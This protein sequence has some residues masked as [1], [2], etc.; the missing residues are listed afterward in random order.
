LLF[1][2]IDSK[3][4]WFATLGAGPPPPNDSTTDCNSF[5]LISNFNRV[6]DVETAPSAVDRL[7]Y[8]PRN[9]DE[10][11]SK[12]IE[13]DANYHDDLRYC[14]NPNGKTTFNS[15]SFAA[16]LLKAASVPLPK[17]PETPLFFH[18]GWSEPI[19]SSQFQPH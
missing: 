10:L 1:S 6:G 14:W 5:Q 17:F 8:D 15:N 4:N 12:L 9:E 18:V 11:V 13:L 16:G 19:P 3:G 7:L 2:N